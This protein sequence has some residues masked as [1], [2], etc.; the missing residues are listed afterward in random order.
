MANSP[1]HGLSAAPGGELIVKDRQIDC[2]LPQ[3]PRIIAG[4]NIVGKAMEVQTELLGGAHLN[5]LPL[6]ETTPNLQAFDQALLDCGIPVS[7][8][9]RLGRREGAD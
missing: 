1:T 6:N 3:V 8:E 9:G 2:L 5:G 7:D 4:V